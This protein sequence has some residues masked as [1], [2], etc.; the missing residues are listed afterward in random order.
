M[1]HRTCVPSS[2]TQLN[3][4]WGNVLILFHDN[5]CVKKYFIPTI[6]ISLHPPIEHYQIH[7]PDPLINCGNAPVNPKLSG[8]HAV[9]HL[10]P[11][12]LSKY[13]CPYKNCLTSASPLGILLS[14][15]TQLPPTT[16]NFPSLTFF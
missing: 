7:L 6:S 4:E 12:L 5:F 11:N 13:L 16:W 3:D 15:S 2:P 8:N 14:F 1:W 10:T 9:S